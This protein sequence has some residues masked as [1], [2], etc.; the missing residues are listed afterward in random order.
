MFWIWLL[1]A[2]IVYV[3]IGFF[4]SGLLAAWAEEDDEID[5][6]VVD[7]GSYVFFAWPFFWCCV[8]GHFFGSWLMFKLRQRR[9]SSNG[10]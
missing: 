6:L 4:S 5:D 2:I 1:A 3:L 10:S 8:C 7:H 9:R